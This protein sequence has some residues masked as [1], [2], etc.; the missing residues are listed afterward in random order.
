MFFFFFFGGPA[1]ILPAGSINWH[2]SSAPKHFRTYK[3]G[4]NSF[5]FQ[6]IGLVFIPIDSPFHALSII[7]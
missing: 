3:N 7:F 4:D 2:R 6:R 5:I 1:L